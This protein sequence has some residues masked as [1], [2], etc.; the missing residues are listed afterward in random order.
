[1]KKETVV[2]WCVVDNRGD[3]NARMPSMNLLFTEPQ[4][5]LK[6]VGRLFN[7]HAFW[8]CPSILDMCTNTYVIRAPFDMTVHFTKNDDGSLNFRTPDVT[9]VTVDTF[10]EL[11][12]DGTFSMPPFYLFYSDKS[13]M[14]EVIPTPIIDAPLTNM[15][16]LAGTFDIGKW[17]RPVEFAVRVLDFAKPVEIKK[18]DALLCVRFLPQDGSVVRLE[19]VSFTNELE[20]LVEACVHVKHTV[21]G[22]ALKTL[23]KLA[24]PVLALFHKKK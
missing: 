6:E 10:F 15:A 20:D 8:R 24:E 19:R 21:K 18:G 16:L 9:Q 22:L 17:V 7:K 1:L 11:R 12:P 3:R 13:L 2:K 14:M 23:Y 5:L 4:H